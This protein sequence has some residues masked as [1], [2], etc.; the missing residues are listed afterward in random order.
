MYII[1]QFLIGQKIHKLHLL[2][3]LLINSGL[4]SRSCCI[5]WLLCKL[6]TYHI[7]SIKQMSVNNITYAARLRAKAEL[8]GICL[9]RSV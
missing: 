6:T 2:R 7:K 9:L 4:H 8:K 5:N 1:K 3:T